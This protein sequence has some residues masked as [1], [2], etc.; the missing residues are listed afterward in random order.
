MGFEQEINEAVHNAHR[1]VDMERFLQ[2]SHANF[3]VAINSDY[4][5]PK[6]KEPKVRELMYQLLAYLNG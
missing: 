1:K 6:S 4:P 2:N 3:T 5:I